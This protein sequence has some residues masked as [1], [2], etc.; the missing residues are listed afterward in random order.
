MCAKDFKWA[1]GSG[2]L[3]TELQYNMILCASELS[4]ESQHFGT[5]GGPWVKNAMWLF[6]LLAAG[7]LADTVPRH[8]RMA[9]AQKAWHTWCYIVMHDSCRKNPLKCTLWNILFLK[10]DHSTRWQYDI[11]WLKQKYLWSMWPSFASVFCTKNA[12]ALRKIFSEHLSISHL[13]QPTACPKPIFGHSDFGTFLWREKQ[14]SLSALQHIQNRH[15]I[16]HLFC[17][18]L[19]AVKIRWR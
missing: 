18:S 3:E 9:A 14:N 2:M 7:V 5:S 4:W 8:E 15:L 19:I 13:E 17:V 16:L 10:E 6:A 11:I 1:E 12:A